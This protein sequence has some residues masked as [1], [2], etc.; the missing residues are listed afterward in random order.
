[1]NINYIIDRK[2]VKFVTPLRHATQWRT[3]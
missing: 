3:T 2:T 1:M